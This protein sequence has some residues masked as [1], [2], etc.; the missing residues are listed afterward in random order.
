[1]I[2]HAF[3][4]EVVPAV[5]TIH[6]INTYYGYRQARRVGLSWC[7]E[8]EDVNVYDFPQDALGR[9]IPYGIYDINRNCG[10]VYVGNSADTSEFAIDAIS[11]WWNKEG[12]VSFF[13]LSTRKLYNHAMIRFILP[14]PYPRSTKFYATNKLTS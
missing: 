12:A 5:P 2:F 13:K 8:P 4:Y 9:A 3:F 1:M 6:L 14:L 10:H 7:K 11:S